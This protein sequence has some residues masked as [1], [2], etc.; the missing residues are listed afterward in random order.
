MPA[1]E[2]IR[3]FAETESQFKIERDNFTYSQSV[4]VEASTMSTLEGTAADSASDSD[5]VFTP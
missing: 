5:I 2:I 3:K 1:S 4:L